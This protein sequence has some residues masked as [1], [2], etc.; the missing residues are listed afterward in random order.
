M[1][2]SLQLLK[3]Q[4]NEIQVNFGSLLEMKKCIPKDLSD[5]P[6]YVT[7]AELIVHKLF[8]I[9]IPNYKSLSLIGLYPTSLQPAIFKKTFSAPLNTSFN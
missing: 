5:S 4:M 8:T 9:H 7:H 6:I 1:I 3:N 2:T